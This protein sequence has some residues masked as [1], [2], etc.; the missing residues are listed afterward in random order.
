[1]AGGDGAGGYKVKWFISKKDKTV[2]RQ[3]SDILVLNERKKPEITFSRLK[4]I[5]KK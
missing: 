5:Y 3:V 1:L 2:K 4:R